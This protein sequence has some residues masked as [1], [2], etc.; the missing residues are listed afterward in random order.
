MIF[1]PQIFLP[2]CY[3]GQFLLPST[4]HPDTKKELQ[5]IL[6][7]KNGVGRERATIE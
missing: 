4:S 1:L 3:L 6:N 5:D 2:C 7:A